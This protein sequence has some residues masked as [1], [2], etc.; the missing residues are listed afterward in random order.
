MATLKVT[1]QELHAT[2]RNMTNLTNQMDNVAVQ[3]QQHIERLQHDVWDAGSG[4]AFVQQFNHVNSN[5]RGAHAALSNHY[6]NLA[7]A[8]NVYERIE[9]EQTQR[10][11][12][13]DAS[14]IF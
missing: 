5:R 3:M 7:E 13:L 9:A 6:R 1:P 2:A 4:R 11:S 10:A 8:A 12:S 14:R